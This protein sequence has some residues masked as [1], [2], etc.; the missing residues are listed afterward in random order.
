[1]VIQLRLRDINPR[2]DIFLNPS[3]SPELDI[4]IKYNNLIFFT[5]NSTGIF[6]L[7]EDT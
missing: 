4:V 6:R 1:M 5:Y 2:T 3:S 7:K